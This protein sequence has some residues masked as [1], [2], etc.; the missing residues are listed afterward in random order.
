MI[1][2]QLVIGGKPRKSEETF[3]VINPAT[4]AIIGKCSS[5][6]SADVKEAIDIADDAF[7][8]WS[9]IP[10][11]IRAEIIFR[12]A[13]NIRARQDELSELITKEEGK[14]LRES[15]GEV[16]DA[17]KACSYFA[18]EGRRIRSSVVPSEQSEKQC[19]SI[20]RPLGVI[21][22]I[23][24]WN[25]PI[26]TPFWGLAPAL[27]MG[28][29]AVFKPSSLT[30]LIGEKIVELF[31]DAGLPDGVLN[32]LTGPGAR[33]GQDL[34]G[35]SK[36]KA[37]TFTGESKTGHYISDMNSKFFRR[38]VLELG[39]KNP[40]IVAKDAEIDTTVAAA[41]FAAFGNTGQRCTAASRIIVEE[42]VL[43]EFVRKFSEQASKLVVGNGMIDGV[44]MGPLVSEG[45]LSKA[46]SYVKIGQDEGAKLVSG[47]FLYT[48]ERSKGFFCP[49]TIFSEVTNDMRIS[50][51]EI[52]APV[53][54]IISAKN[55][56]EALTM[57]NDTK[58][59]LSSAIY[60]KDLRNAFLAIEQIDAGVTFVNQGTASIEVMLPYGGV[61]DSGIGK[62]LGEA[63]LEQYTETK[64]VYIDYSYKRRPWFYSWKE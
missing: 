39:G 25:F 19:I 2:G 43:N 33:V 11:P 64:A 56:D 63:A 15:K 45:A 16:M 26:S 57:A 37:V 24:P 18:S 9:K 42:P 22:I 4:K 36:V 59:G 31:L 17:F 3:D 47:G 34:L 30:S 8:T 60:T 49:P 23:T 7:L 29:T 6:S 44:E 21:A 58:Y 48:D 61:K 46:M 38:Q 35:N 54:S 10:A 20:R 1:Q 5:A 12:V 62:E 40:L 53:V 27:V 52:F 50:Q 14:T 55:L 28:N 32:L 51:E 13:E 41:L